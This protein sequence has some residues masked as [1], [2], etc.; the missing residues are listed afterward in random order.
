MELDTSLVPIIRKFNRFY[1]KVLGL[2]DKQLLDSNY[3]L[4]EARVLYEI[5][6]TKH[7]TA[8]MLIEHLSIDAGYLS[9]ILKR[10]D[11]LGLTYRVQSEKDGRSSLLFLSTLG[12]E[13]LSK[14]N[15]LSEEQI[16]NL[17]V[18]LPYE[19]QMS[20]A[21]SMTAIEREL[22]GNPTES[23]FSIRTELKPGDV[24]MLIHMHGWIYAEECGYNH[25]FEGYVCKTFYDLLQNYSSDKDRFWLAEADGKLI[26]S[27]AIIGQSNERAQLRWFMLHPEARGRGLGKKLL[28]EA[29]S[30]CRERGFK[31]VFLETTGDQ[32][33]A[34]Q[35]YEKAGF[36]KISEL[37]VE[38]WGKRLIE[39]TYELNLQ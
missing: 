4:S 38:S 31:F 17:I 28:Q 35:M 23:R 27:I 1:T 2:L 3:S 9:R 15:I 10:F 33:T 13:T 8:K 16:R 18:G 36:K 30:Y 25:L 20:I 22:S 32:N 12:E 19:S 37:E 34:I 6:N 14:M 11:K 5:G 26:G 29:I 24:G 21:R 39:Q 7:C